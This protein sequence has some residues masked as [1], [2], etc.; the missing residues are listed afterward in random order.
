MEADK[1][2]DK[3]KKKNQIKSEWRD[4]KSWHGRE[5]AEVSDKV[6]ENHIEEIDIL[7]EI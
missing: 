4:Q 7:A 5:L 6:S 2:D 3:R 1:H